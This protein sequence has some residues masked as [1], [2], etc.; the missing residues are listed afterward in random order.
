LRASSKA[1]ARDVPGQRVGTDAA[2]IEIVIVEPGADAASVFGEGLAHAGKIGGLA[3]C[4]QFVELHEHCGL[5]TGRC[6]FVLAVC[7]RGSERVGRWCVGKGGR[8]FGRI[9][10]LAGR[11]A[12][13][14]L[15]L[16][17]RGG[18]GEEKSENPG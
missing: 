8:G 15:L 1:I 3:L 5:A 18:S 17:R 12:R 13:R 9:G 6:L 2:K 16:S 11:S 4:P 14:G 7:W 10:F